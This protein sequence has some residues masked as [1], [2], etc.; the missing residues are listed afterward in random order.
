M[1]H[2]AA[3]KETDEE[4]VNAMHSSPLRIEYFMR[5]VATKERNHFPAPRAS[6]IASIAKTVELAK[7]G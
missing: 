6:V 5:S 4:I 7:A 2:T 3:G 1:L